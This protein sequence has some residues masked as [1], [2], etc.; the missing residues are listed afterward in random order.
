MV[1][2]QEKGGE[3]MVKFLGQAKLNDEQLNRLA[4]VHCVMLYLFMYDKE[5]LAGA[6]PRRLKTQEEWDALWN[7]DMDRSIAFRFSALAL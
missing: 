5:A 2:L 1:D 7:P 3:G 4:K 6:G